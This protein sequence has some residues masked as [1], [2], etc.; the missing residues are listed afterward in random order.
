MAWLNRLV[1]LLGGKN[2]A[3]NIV[4]VGLP[5]CGKS[6]IMLQLKPRQEPMAILTPTIPLPCNAEKFQYRALT[7]VAFDLGE[8]TGFGNPWEDFYRDCHGIIFVFDSSDRVNMP[9]AK[10]HLEKVLRNP[11]IANRNIPLML[12]ANKCDLPLAIPSLQCADFFDLK[13]ITSK[14]WNVFST[15]ALTGE[16]FNEALD[17]FSHQL[18][19]ARTQLQQHSQ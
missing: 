18:R 9:A 13:Q 10:A 2:I 15:D 12:F 4:I 16:G 6:T 1:W 19:R 7:F 5:Y 8:M 11:Y 17:W 3:A 14:V